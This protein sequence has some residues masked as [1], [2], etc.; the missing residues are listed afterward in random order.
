[1]GAVVSEH[2]VV[3]SESIAHPDGDGFLTD[4]KVHETHNLVFE[5]KLGDFLLGR[6]NQKHLAIRV[7]QAPVGVR[8]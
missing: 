1:M 2:L 5:I 7:Q 8:L 6:S 4:A 3:G